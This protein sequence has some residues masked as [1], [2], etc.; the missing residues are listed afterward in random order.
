MSDRG[1]TD[2]STDDRRSRGVSTVRTVAIAAL[3]VTAAALAGCGALGGGGGGGGDG[4]DGGAGSANVDAPGPL[5]NKLDSNA[6]TIYQRVEDILGTDTEAP[7]VVI[8]PVNSP[9]NASNR[10]HKLMLG[11][12][13]EPGQLESNVTG[14][15]NPDDHAVFVNE[16]LFA[17]MSAAE[18]EG[19]LAYYFA[20]SIHVRNGWLND[21][22]VNLDNLDT[23][24]TYSIRTL[25][26]G[27][28]RSS[29]Q[30][31]VSEHMDGT[32]GPLAPAG[33]QQTF[34]DMT[35]F[36]WA[37]DGASNY[38]GVEYV[39][40]ATDSPSDIPSL[41]ENAPATT[42]QMLHDSDE[43]PLELSM[44]AT[45]SNW[46]TMPRM[47]YLVDSF[48]ELGTRAVLRSAHSES[49]AA[50]AAEGW[51]ND[52]AVTFR[53]VQNGSAGAVWTH[54]WDTAEDADEFASA[55][56][57]LSEQ[58]GDPVTFNVTQPAEDATIVVAHRGNFT[59]NA[60]ISYEDN[61]VTIRVGN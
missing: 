31:Y 25:Y 53:S 36:E 20:A 8:Q 50:A 12:P 13:D 52:R 35:A 59:N 46:W 38:Y 10:F 14:M 6:G 37:V 60:D 18:A 30:T 34:D 55:V 58:R 43:E 47:P 33:E 27:T 45:H 48:G 15:Y 49:D 1:T 9:V 17:E 54:R 42:E 11:H 29:Y 32:P 22:S 5:N 61:E 41:Y 24:G 19:T 3:V 4:G 28:V 26:Q 2:S 21:T 16:D 7:R 23:T 57:A 40:G 39:N 51:G 56:E 44:N